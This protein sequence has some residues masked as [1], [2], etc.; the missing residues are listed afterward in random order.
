MIIVDTASVDALEVHITRIIDGFD[1]TLDDIAGAAAVE[2]AK[3]GEVEWPSTS[4]SE[5]IYARDRSVKRFEVEHEGTGRYAVVNT[6]SYSGYT[7]KGYTRQRGARSAGPYA[8]R[9]GTDY[10]QKMLSLA[11]PEIVRAI[12]DAATER[13]ED[14]RG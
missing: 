8:A 9:G 5:N 11:Q 2:V 6:A 10:S 4:H 1:G 3:A 13:L 14:R 7:D 12:E